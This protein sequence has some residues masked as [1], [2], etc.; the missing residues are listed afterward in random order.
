MLVDRIASASP[1]GP[2]LLTTNL[3]Q[4]P[5][6]IFIII[7]AHVIPSNFNLHFILL[8]TLINCP[9]LLEEEGAVQGILF[10]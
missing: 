7:W 9:L 5:Q 10:V 2:P 3:P 6:P 4:P 1:Q 8:K